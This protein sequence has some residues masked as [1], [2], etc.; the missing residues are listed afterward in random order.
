MKRLLIAI[1]VVFVLGGCR[2]SGSGYLTGTRS[3]DFVQEVPFGMVFIPMGSFNMG[4]ND[5]DVPY[6]VNSQTKT[7]SVS[8]FCMDETEI[9]NDEYRQFVNWVRDSIARTL[10]GA[11]NDEYL[12]AETKD[13]DPIDPPYLNWDIDI[14]WNGEEEK[15]ILE[16]MFY[17]VHERF[18][19]R[20]EIDTR[21]LMYEYYWIDYQK[22]AL[23]ENRYNFTTKSYGGGITDRSAFVRKG[24]V[25]VYP[26]TLAWI[27]DFT[28]SYNEPQSNMYFWHPAYDNYPVVGVNWMQARAFSIWRTQLLN[29]FLHYQG[30]YIYNDFR[31]PTEAE[32]EWAAR[33]GL[34]QNMYPWGGPYLRHQNGCFLA[35]FKPLRG[36]YIDDGGFYTVIVGHYDPN[37]FGLYDMAGNVSEWTWNAFDESYYSFGHDL[38]MDYKYE[39][40]E[41]DPP[42][43]KRKVIRGGSWK[44]IGYFLQC[45][46][47][48][49]EY[50]DTAKC[51]I[52]F[53]NVQDYL[54]R[55]INDSKGS[56][57]YY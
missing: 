32:W 29:S 7:V 53:R 5:Q 3:I 39:A 15:E 12:I 19:R 49:Y 44:D 36:N 40:E 25:N 47:R 16:E 20:K 17:P 23:K 27:H 51:Y 22:A 46:T 13:G 37:D 33:G 38:N 42:A 34:D 31:L 55:D 18:Y 48:S 4:P 10:L 8:P 56:S 30:E 28:Y 50:Q 9:T 1:A 54:G 41:S 52:G 21:K 43:L 11:N 57:N 6:A 24:V 35:N 14:D 45:G 2:N 26:D